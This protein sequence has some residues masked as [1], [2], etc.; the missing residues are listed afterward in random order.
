MNLKLDDIVD[1]LKDIQKPC[2]EIADS[3]VDKRISL[4]EEAVENMVTDISEMKNKQTEIKEEMKENRQHA[5]FKYYELNEDTNE[6]FK[7]ITVRLNEN[8]EYSTAEYH[9]IRVE[10]NDHVNAANT[11]QRELKQSYDE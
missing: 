1:T 10:T 8:R 11:K 6:R 2:S 7:E 9:E 4:L 5:N 3:G